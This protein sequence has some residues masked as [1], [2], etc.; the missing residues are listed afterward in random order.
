MASGA[1]P[2]HF[3]AGTGSLLAGWMYGGKI[4]RDHGAAALGTNIS[5]GSSGSLGSAVGFP[6]YFAP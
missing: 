1:F 5:K 2:L 4:I 6:N 3:P